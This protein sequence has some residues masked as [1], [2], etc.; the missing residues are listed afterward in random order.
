MTVKTDL[1]VAV[2][3]RVSSEHQA[4]ANSIDSQL[5]ELRARSAADGVDLRA[6]LEFVDTG[7]SGAPLVRPA[8]ERLRDIAAAMD[9]L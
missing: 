1:Q 8:L 2:Y 4:E 6:V 5:A 3:A 7:Y 9:R